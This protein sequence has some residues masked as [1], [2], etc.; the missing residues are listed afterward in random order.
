MNVRSNYFFGGHAYGT[1]SKLNSCLHLRQE[2]L[3]SLFDDE[4]IVV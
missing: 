1:P 4:F 2:H 3:C